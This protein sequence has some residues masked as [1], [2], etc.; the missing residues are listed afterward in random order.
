M[1]NFPVSNPH[2]LLIDDNQDGLLVRRA[3]LEEV[4]YR[5]S[6][7]RTGEEALKLLE[8]S[9]FDVMV[10]DY[11]M[12]RMNGSELIRRV[13]AADPNARVILLSGFV[14]AMGLTEES[15]GADAVIAKS[16]REA[17]HLMRW[18]KRLV[19][20]TAARKKPPATQRKL[21]VARARAISR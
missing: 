5:V 1:K 4:G 10:T 16:S 6:I 7:A 3:L 19:S 8:S 13:R 12:P 18:I 9:R 20:Q 2:I 11:R 17:T 21:P 15:T 14:E